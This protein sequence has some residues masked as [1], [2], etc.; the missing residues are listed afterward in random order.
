QQL[1]QQADRQAASALDK[2]LAAIHA[3]ID[4]RKAGSKAF[5]ERV[6]SLRGKWETVKAEIGYNSD[7]ARFLQEAFAEHIFPIEELE[8]A[9]SAAVRSYL[10]ELES[11]EDDLLVRLRADLADDE[12]PRRAIPALGSDDAFRRHYHQL[13]QRVSQDL[14]SDLAAVAARELFI[15]HAGNIATDLTLMAGAA[16]AGRLGL[17]TAILAAGA[18]STWQTLGVGL[19]VCFVLDAVVNRIIKAAG[20]DVEEQIAARIEETLSDLGRTIT[21]GDPEA[22]DQLEQ[23]KVMQRADPNEKVRTA[24]AE[25]IASVEAGTQLYGLRRELSKISAARASVRNETLRR[26]I[27]ENE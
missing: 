20:Y 13:S 3:F 4:E 17:S 2:H 23:L 26:L 5:A 11:L 7:Y 27:Q 19:I 15:W 22:R 9:V 8:K 1:L 14:R 18:E 12:L 21:D 6:V 24:C 16:I 25:A 10:A